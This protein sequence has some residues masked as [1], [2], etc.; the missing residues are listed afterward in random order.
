MQRERLNFS[1]LF[2]FPFPLSIFMFHSFDW[3]ILTKCSKNNCVYMVR[4]DFPIDRVMITQFVFVLF[5][6]IIL[7]WLLNQS[8]RLTQCNKFGCDAWWEQK[9][10]MCQEP[11][12]RTN[13]FSE[14]HYTYTNFQRNL[15]AMHVIATRLNECENRLCRLKIGIKK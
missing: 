11:N 12:E 9:H 5:F 10:R 3:L 13:V 1:F 4:N 14:R 2:L 7:R 8:H 15:W 6:F